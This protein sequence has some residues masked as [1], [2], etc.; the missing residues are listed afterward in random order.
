[1]STNDEQH[2]AAQRND[3]DV[4]NS[5]PHVKEACMWILEAADEAVKNSTLSE[6]AY[7]IACRLT[8]D[9]F[10]GVKR[11]V[12]SALIKK[13]NELLKRQN[14]LLKKQIE[15]RKDYKAEEEEHLKTKKELLAL[16]KDHRALS[17]DYTAQTQECGALLE[18][19]IALQND[20]LTQVNKH[21]ALVKQGTNSMAKQAKFV[22]E[23]YATLER[24]GWAGFSDDDRK[25]LEGPFRLLKKRWTDA[26]ERQDALTSDDYVE[27]ASKRQRMHN[28]SETGVTAEVTGDT[29][30]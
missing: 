20:N 7:T 1:M 30:D 9:E 17:A 22:L 4:G 28:Q 16:S 2:A 27:P 6:G 29:T 19:Y 15:L 8:K 13:Q 25:R 24:N 10:T 23:V 3:G 21:T 14:E 11:D 12:Y 18:K 26:L 5:D